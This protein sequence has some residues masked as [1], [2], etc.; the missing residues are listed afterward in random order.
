M[1]N[2]T[3][4]KNA[5]IIYSYYTHNVHTTYARFTHTYTHTHY[6]Q[7]THKVFTMNTHYIHVVPIKDFACAK[8]TMQYARKKEHAPVYVR[9]MFLISV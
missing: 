7:Y 5:H 1:H 3:P 8:L 6:T 2:T 4:Q 9:A